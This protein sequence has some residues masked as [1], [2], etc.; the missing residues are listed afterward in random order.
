MSSGLPLGQ[1]CNMARLEAPRELVADHLP[2]CT[3][4]DVKICCFV[5]L[6]T[7]LQ[8]LLACLTPT[9]SNMERLKPGSLSRCTPCCL[10]LCSLNSQIKKQ[11]DENHYHPSPPR[12]HQNKAAQL[13]FLDSVL[14][15]HG[16]HPPPLHSPPSQTTGVKTWDIFNSFFCWIR[17][18]LL[19]QLR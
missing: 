8:S 17:F 14:L 3:G 2:S 5:E 13:R 19:L 1:M 11:P 6:Q 9:V 16:T 7:A 18:H 4:P 10:G 12:H 15:L